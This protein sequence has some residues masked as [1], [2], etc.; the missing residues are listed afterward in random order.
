MVAVQK[1]INIIMKRKDFLLKLTAL[2]LSVIMLFTGCHNSR[3]DR[4]TDDE[5]TTNQTEISTEESTTKSTQD[6]VKDPDSDEA[7]A[8]QESFDQF[9]TDEYVSSMSYSLVST[10]FDL[11]EPEKFGIT[12]YESIWGDFSVEESDSEES[13]DKEFYDT[14]LTYDYDLLTYDQKLTYDTLKAYLENSMALDEYYYFSE[15]LSP[16]SGTQF[17][18]P[19]IL[20]E[21]A[22]YDEDDIKDYLDVLSSCDEYVNSLLE[23]EKWRAEQG[24]AMTDDAIDEVIEQC[25]DILSADEPA[26]L[27]VINEVIDQCDFLS[28]EAK[29]NYKSQ[30]KQLAIDNFIPAYQNIISELGKLKGSRSVEGGLCKYDG[31]KEYYEALVRLYTGSDKSLDEL[32][33][34]IESDL[35]SGIMK[36]SRLMAKDPDI[37]T[38]MYGELDYAY[39]D[40]D[41]ILTNL[42]TMLQ[43]DFPAPVC[44]EYDLKYVAKSMESSS[45]PAFYLIPQY[46]NYTRNIIYVNQ[47]EEYA[48]M[49]LFPLLAH[50]GMPGH[51]YQNNY[52]LSLNPHPIR[53]LLHFGGYAEGWAKY[54]EHYSYNWSGLDS[55]IAE[56]LAIDDGFGF[57]LYSRVDI[58]VNYEGWNTDDIA[59]FLDDYIVVDEDITLELYNLFINDPA[60]YLQYY[61]GRLE[62]EELR[63]DA[64]DMLGDDFDIK[65][66]HTFI[67][68]VGPTYY[69]IIRDRMNTWAAQY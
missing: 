36:L 22:I 50:E 4:F 20:S 8:V 1:G 33:E 57:A 55:N 46:D 54:V 60:T 41:E 5:S 34:V 43:E 29:E 63:D 6:P 19:L 7:K 2:S 58:G 67:L 38:K 15:Y 27:P 28:S 49:D 16:S 31:G 64:E 48:D 42:M 40:P 13:E 14:L 21:F 66:F 32:I 37:T 53:S 3:F 65:E 62:I 23:Y 12:E 45:N 30:I 59:D 44:T 69:D 51:M 61:I 56:A 47:N 17:E 39:T 26:F 24:Y 52:F 9:L 68:T 10:H 11:K 25:N 18:L 35:Y